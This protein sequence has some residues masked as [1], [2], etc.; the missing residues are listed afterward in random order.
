GSESSTATFGGGVDAAAIRVDAA[1][2]RVRPPHRHDQP[3]H[4]QDEPE[5]AATGEEEGKAQDVKAAGSPVAEEKPGGLKP[6]DVARAFAGQQGQRRGLGTPV[7]DSVHERANP[8]NRR[9]P[10]VARSCPRSESGSGSSNA[11]P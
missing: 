1:D 10:V 4:Q 6:A 11:Q 9:R 7:G 5:A 2:L 8:T 3:A